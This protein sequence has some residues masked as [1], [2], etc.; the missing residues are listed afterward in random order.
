[1]GGELSD[2]AR[3]AVALF[4]LGFVI[5]L[6]STIL[7]FS[8]SATSEQLGSVQGALTN[9]QLSTFDDYDQK[10]KYGSQISSIL[11]YFRQRDIAVVV[12]TKSSGTKAYNYGCLLEGATRGQGANGS[13]VVYTLTLPNKL[14]GQSWYKVNI[15]VD[16]AGV[17]THNVNFLPT[18]QTGTET[19]IPTTATFRS[20]LIKDINNEIVGVALTQ[21]D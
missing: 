15:A 4:A 11:S 7:N 8:R 20:E 10:S 17:K 14:E 3:I 16:A 12:R 13:G 19:F 5:S 1:M 6:I 21:M 2:G 9:I 18:Q